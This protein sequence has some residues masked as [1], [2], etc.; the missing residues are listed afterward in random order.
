MTAAEARSYAIAASARHGRPWSFRCA[1]DT[2]SSAPRQVCGWK[3][4]RGCSSA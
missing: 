4:R 3:F 1:V 2:T